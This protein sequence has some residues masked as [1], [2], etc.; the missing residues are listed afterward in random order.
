LRSELTT[1]PPLNVEAKKLGEFR[2]AITHRRIRVVVYLF[3]CPTNYQFQLA[4]S[5]WR[6]IDPS[7]IR[8][9]AVSSMTFKAL[10]LLAGNEATSD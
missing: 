7:E 9:H 4:H 1:I 10:K 5:G 3:D 8:G 6:W 2:H